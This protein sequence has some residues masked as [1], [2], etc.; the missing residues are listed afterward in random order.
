[1]A[2]DSRAKATL[3]D[4]VRERIVVALVA[5]PFAFVLSV[6]MRVVAE[7]CRIETPGWL[8]VDWFVPLFGRPISLSGGFVLPDLGG[9]W[10]LLGSCALP[11]LVCL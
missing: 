2:D 9:S 5:V 3:N 6:A 4:D 7:L 11:L 10:F 1:M 8:F